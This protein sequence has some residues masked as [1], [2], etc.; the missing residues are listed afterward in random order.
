MRFLLCFLSLF[1]SFTSNDL[2][3]YLPFTETEFNFGKIKEIDGEVSHVFWFVNNTSERKVMYRALT[4]CG[5]TNAVIENRYVDPG[6]T[7]RVTVTYN[8]EH[9]VEEFLREVY[10][11]KYPSDTVSILR[12][13][14]IVDSIIY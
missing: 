7:A 1:F 8:P 2:E 3:P 5:C 10:I 6:D 11:I 13:S 12:I 14:G 9:N 4:S